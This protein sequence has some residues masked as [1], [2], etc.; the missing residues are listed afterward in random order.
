[1]GK[2]QKMIA[3]SSII[4]CCPMHKDAGIFHYYI[5]KIW[6]IQIGKWD[7]E[8]HFAYNQTTTPPPHLYPLWQESVFTALAFTLNTKLT[9]IHDPTTPCKLVSR[10]ENSSERDRTL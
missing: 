5:F 3:I 8:F 6:T 7:L 10:Y 1:M 9:E 2:V 4:L